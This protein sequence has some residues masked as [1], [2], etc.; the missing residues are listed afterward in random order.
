VDEIC[1]FKI[2][3]SKLICKELGCKGQHIKWLHV[4]LKEA[5]ARV[6]EGRQG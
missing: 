1:F 5:L 2:N 3:K 6:R 4:M